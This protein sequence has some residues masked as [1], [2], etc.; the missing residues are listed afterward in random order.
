MVNNFNTINIDEN[1][2]EK[3]IEIDKKIKDE[4]SKGSNIDDKKVTKLM[5]EQMLRG[6][7][8]TQNP[9]I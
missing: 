6:L 5:F 9:L 7:Y 4:F 1:A 2:V 8:I 3:V